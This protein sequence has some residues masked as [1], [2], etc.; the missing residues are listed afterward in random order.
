MSNV[1]G[2]MHNEVTEKWLDGLEEI[3]GLTLSKTFR[4]GIFGKSC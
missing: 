1:G 3:D 2:L 4:G